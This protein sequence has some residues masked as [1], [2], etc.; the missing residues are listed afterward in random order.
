G[1]LRPEV[2]SDLWR[3]LDTDNDDDIQEDEF[4]KFAGKDGIMDM[5]DWKV[6]QEQAEKIHKHDVDQYNVD[7]RN[8]AIQTALGSG[9]LYLGSKLHQKRKAGQAQERVRAKE[10]Q[11][12]HQR[13]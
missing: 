10:K 8:H 2:G 7:M 13:E 9:A 4:K 6:V 3:V 1:W 11:D 12:A 5:H